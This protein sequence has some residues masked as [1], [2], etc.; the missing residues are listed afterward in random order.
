MGEVQQ[1]TRAPERLAWT[2]GE[3]VIE[4]PEETGVDEQEE[5]EQ[6]LSAR[7]RV[8]LSGV[9]SRV[10]AFHLPG[11]HPQENHGGGVK[12]FDGI[13]VMD[14]EEYFDSYGEIAEEDGIDLGEGIALTAR[15]FVNGDLHAVI[16]LPDGRSQVISE[17]FPDTMRQLADDIEE[18]LDWDIDEDE[19][20]PGGLVAEVE[21]DEDGHNMY[22]ALDEDGDV[23]LRRCQRSGRRLHGPIP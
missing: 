14:R 21:S 4:L 12:V 1:R 20:Y 15:Y 7:H 3:L 9:A 2:E 6:G 17:L 10:R 19:E 5:A 13:K 16:D 8:A 11:K 18:L 22:L 23:R